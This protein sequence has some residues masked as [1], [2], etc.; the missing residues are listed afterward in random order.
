MKVALIFNKSLKCTTGWYVFRSFKK[1]K[2]EVNIFSPNEIKNILNYRPDF[3]LAIDSGEH[4]IF[5]I[6]IHPNAIWLID[7]HLSYT[8]DKIMSKSFDIIFIA[9]KNDYLKFKKFFKN[10][11]WLPLAA[12]LDYHGKKCLLKRYDVA[13]IGNLGY[14][15]RKFILKKL[16]SKYPTSY[17]GNAD[18]SE[19]GEIYSASKVIVNYSVKNDINMRIFEALCSG[20]LLITN[21]I[22]NNGLEELF[23]V[24]KELI[25]FKSFGELITKIDYYIE[26]ESDREK[27]ANSGHEKVLKFHLYDHRVK[28]IVD[29]ITCFK[30]ISEFKKFGKLKLY[31]LKLTL[32]F[33]E[34][35]WKVIKVI[36]K[37]KNKLFETIWSMWQ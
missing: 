20:S 22:K 36:N 19:I 5:D 25:T 1:L 15:R 16:K 31:Y 21:E 27:I 34:L 18:C 23:E 37:R 26:N 7:T 33:A 30:N 11:Y 32:F 17:I 9:Q 29:K 13:F 2:Y 10:V 3:V 8:C 4:Y 14:G 12:D 35:L 28:F 6:D 24:N